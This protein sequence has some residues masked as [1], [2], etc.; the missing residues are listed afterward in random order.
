VTGL[1]SGAGL[2]G[3]LNGL[4][5]FFFGFFF[6]RPRLSRLPMICSFHWQNV[7]FAFDFLPGLMS[8]KVIREF[9]MP[10]WHQSRTLTPPHSQPWRSD[11]FS[12]DVTLETDEIDAQL[13][14][15]LVSRNKPFMQ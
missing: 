3:P 1:Y 7:Y 13:L 9:S 15:A 6:S 10:C 5:T 12:R 2:A 11:R 4:L 8:A 14:A